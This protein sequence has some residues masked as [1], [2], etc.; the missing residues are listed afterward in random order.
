[1]V[2]KMSKPPNYSD[3]TIEEKMKET[4]KIN[5]SEQPP[6]CMLC[7]NEVMDNNMVCNRCWEA[8]KHIPQCAICG[9]KIPEVEMF[10][11]KC[12]KTGKY[13]W[14]REKMCEKCNKPLI[15]IKKHNLW[16]CKKHTNFKIE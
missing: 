13:N 2:L 14:K 1:M 5:T 15:Y 4:Q 16:C 8:E 11:I 3:M 6:K 12:T 10:C 7:S 9:G